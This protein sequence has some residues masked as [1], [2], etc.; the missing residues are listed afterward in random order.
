MTRAWWWTGVVVVGVLAGVSLATLADRKAR[1]V[2]YFSNWAIYRPG[3]GSYK[4]SDIPIDKCTHIIYSFIGVSNVT[5]EVLVLDQELDVQQNGFKNFTDL[6]KSRPGLKSMLAIGGWGEGGKKYSQMAS[7]P[8]RRTSLIN[9][10]IQYMKLYGFDGFDLDWE[11]PGATDRGGT[12]KDKDNFRDFVLELRAAFDKVGLGWEI[13]MAV[14]VAKF[15][16]QEGYHVQELC[17]HMD[18]IHVMTYDLRGN[19]AGFADVHSPLYKRPFDQWAYETLNVNDGLQL[20]VNLG[21]PKDKLVV[22][23]P[24]YGR[25]FTLG[26]KDVNDLRAPVKKWEGGGAPGPFTGAKG[27][28]AYYEICPLVGDPASGW[29]KKYDNIGK[30]PYAYKDVQ[31]VGY[32]DADSLK[33]KMEY[34]MGNGYGGA[35]TWAID[36][37]DFHGTCGSINPLITV[38]DTYMRN[39]V[40]PQPPATTTTTARTWWKPWK[41]AGASTTTP[42]PV[43]QP[44][45]PVQ[46][47]V[48]PV[49]PVVQ[50]VQ[51]VVQP[52]QPVVQPVQPVQPVVQPGG[53]MDCT[54]NDYFPHADCTKYYW[55]VHG[56]PVELSC[57]KGTFWDPVKKIC[58]WPHAV[59]RTNCNG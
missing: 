26:S 39:Y 11:Y 58:N 7:V 54:Q 16:L 6:A 20:W 40:V 45:Q 5:W 18:A 1:I 59:Q 55:C 36:M 48:Q 41:P 42:Q 35:M 29:T 23:V 28:L 50:P 2:C 53:A 24:F 56:Q 33:I 44:V 52:V 46:P 15:R 19:W 12:F 49:Q 47:V 8:A 22:G 3:A 25:T 4:I 34:I 37:D 27:F 10:V 17:Y 43:V 57:M 21:C 9:S 38:L 51:P 31:W 13:S 14:P 32:E 30:C